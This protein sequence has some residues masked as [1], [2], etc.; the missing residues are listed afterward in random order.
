MTI[1]ITLN[2]GDI[3]CNDI[4]YNINKCNIAN[5]FLSTAIKSFIS[6]VFILVGQS[7]A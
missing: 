7:Q 2:M 1:L 4:S 6:K 5:I 3:T